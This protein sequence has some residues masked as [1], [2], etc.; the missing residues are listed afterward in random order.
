[1]SVRV[2]IFVVFVEPIQFSVDNLFIQCF[3]NKTSLPLFWLQG[4]TLNNF[5]LDKFDL[6]SYVLLKRF[7]VFQ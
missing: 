3:F 4:I 7:S 6:I 5:T 2:I 1:M